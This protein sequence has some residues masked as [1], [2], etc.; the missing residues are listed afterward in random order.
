MKRKKKS[1]D[2]SL[3]NNRLHE[4][5]KHFPYPY[6]IS[7]Q[8]KKIIEQKQNLEGRKYSSTDKDDRTKVWVIGKQK[9]DKSIGFEKFNNKK[10]KRGEWVN[11]WIGGWRWTM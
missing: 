5:S 8:N 9:M 1:W 6:S 2:G 7:K 11:E 3:D 4:H 10:L